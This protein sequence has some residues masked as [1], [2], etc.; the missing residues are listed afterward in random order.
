M[1]EQGG[2]NKGSAI[3][4]GVTKTIEINGQNVTVRK[5]GLIK[6]AKLQSL[7]DNFITSITDFMK[8]Q[9][10][11]KYSIEIDEM[12]VAQNLVSSIVEVLSSNAIAMIDL[13]ELTTDLE[14][15]Y[16]EEYVGI[17][18]A[19]EIIDAVIEVNRIVQVIDKAKKLMMG[20]GAQM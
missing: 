9:S 19:V 17:A 13:I 10:E 15:S 11:I 18:E 5:L 20:L 1:Q 7:L 16:I 14:R 4:S 12:D 2:I 8:R 6:Y 3:V